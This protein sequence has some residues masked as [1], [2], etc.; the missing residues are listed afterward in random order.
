MSFC[1][2]FTMIGPMELLEAKKFVVV[3]YR[4]RVGAGADFGAVYG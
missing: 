2:I 3:R 1:V 4:W